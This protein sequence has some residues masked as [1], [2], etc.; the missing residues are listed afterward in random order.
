MPD[1]VLPTLCAAAVHV[2]LRSV[3]TVMFDQKRVSV[4]A[5]LRPA[6]VFAMLLGVLLLAGACGGGDQSAA[7]EA[8]PA[9]TAETGGMALG[10][11]A[12]AGS[13]DAG[14]AA[15]SGEATAE[16]IEEA[17]T[18]GTPEATVAA[19]VLDAGA[20]ITAGGTVDVYADADPTAPRFGEYP[21][22]TVLAVVEAGGDFGGYPVEVDGRRWYRVRAPDGL[23]GWVPEP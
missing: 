10:G 1:T 17:T 4:R 16:V 6:A 3:Y 5:A 14:A 13:T 2:T 22:G 9:V 18:E 19:P 12:D 21:A 15:P 7:T 8:P 20:L 23:V 11:T